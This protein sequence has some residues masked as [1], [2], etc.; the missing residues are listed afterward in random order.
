[1]EKNKTVKTRKTMKESFYATREKIWNKKRARL[2]LHHSF[3][4]SYREDYLRPLN[5]PGLV[6]HAWTTL[7]IL[8]KNWKLFGG[9][10]IIIVFL[11]MTFV[12]L[13]NEATYQTVQDSLDESSELLQY[14]ELGRVAKSGLLLISTV[15]TGGL[16]KGMTEVQQVFVFLFGSITILV[17]IYYLRHLLA[18]NRPSI[19]DGLYNALTPLITVM[20]MLA[21][22]FI[23]LIPAF[24]FTVL[25]STAVATDF[26]STPLYAF[27]FWLL[28]SLLILLTAY[29]VP[30]S[31]LSMVAVTV[32]GIYPMQAVHAVT[33]LIQG[34]RTKF[35]IRLLFAILFVAVI[36]VIVMVPLIWL[37]LVLKQ[38][39]EWLGELPFIPFMFQ[40]MT[41]FVIIYLTSYIYLYYR[42]MLDDP[43]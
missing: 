38:N 10:M 22:L 15:T 35:I 17:T 5:T 37:D 25:Y 18:G 24:I 34:R 8:F 9:L 36:L 31:L 1:M 11:N 12:G 39:I 30:V 16:T 13:M 43:E 32:P 41:T 26:L 23:H 28:G 21:L 40:I 14:G 33:D 7:K 42:R 20:L 27:L 4:R 2:E 29:L 19:R 6:S 3:K